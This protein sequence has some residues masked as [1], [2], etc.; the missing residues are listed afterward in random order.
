MAIK[1]GQRL[2]S[3]RYNILPGDL[4]QFGYNGKTRFGV[5]VSPDWKG[6][7]DC[8]AFESLEDVSKELLEYITQTTF[9]ID[10]GDLYIDFGN[11]FDFKSFKLADMSA[12]QTIKY[13]YEEEV[14]EN[15]L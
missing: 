7:C 14:T 1:F 3:N 12:I 10:S 6:N 5:V 4:I 11:D 15:E 9:A 8:Y 2:F 13:I